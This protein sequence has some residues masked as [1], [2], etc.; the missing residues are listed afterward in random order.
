MSN[1]RQEITLRHNIQHRKA[2]KKTESFVY[3]WQHAHAMFYVTHCQIC[4]I[5]HHF[6]RSVDM[7][8]PLERNT[9]KTKIT[10]LP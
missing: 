1:K 10:D 4:P 5:G 3:H 6:K 9:F 8:L 2:N 7:I